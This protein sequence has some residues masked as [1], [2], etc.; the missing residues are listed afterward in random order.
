MIIRKLLGNAFSGNKLT[1][2][3]LSPAAI[4][5]TDEIHEFI[6]TGIDSLALDL[7]KDGRVT[8]FGDGL[9]LIRCLLGSA[10]AG[11]KLTDKA[12]SPASPYYEDPDA[13]QVVK[14]N[15]EDLNPY[16]N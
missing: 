4:H 1:E 3:A 11:D 14:Q 15:I 5:N 6:Q 8:A 2:K 9:M 12:L 13:W 10:F 16:L 7:D